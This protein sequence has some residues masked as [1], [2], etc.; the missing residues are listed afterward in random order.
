LYLDPSTDRP[1]RS[2]VVPELARVPFELSPPIRAYPTYPGKRSHEGRYW[3][4]QSGTHVRFESRFEMTALMSLDFRG[5]AARVSSNPFWLLWPPDVPQKR[6][7]PD[8]FVRR[9]DGSVLVVDVKPIARV[10]ERDRA[11]HARTKKLCRELGWDYEEFTTIDRNVERNLRLF[12]AYNHP[13]FALAPENWP[14]NIATARRNDAKGMCL[15]DL[16]TALAGHLDQPAERVLSGIY[17]MLWRRELHVD[18]TH[19]LT[20]NTPVRS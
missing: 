4:S 5:D 16:L 6:H 12:C 14:A 9:K 3:F 8:F 19:P 20:W 13:R 18:M 15:S 17:Y 11:Q 2:R 10:T 1:V 7:A